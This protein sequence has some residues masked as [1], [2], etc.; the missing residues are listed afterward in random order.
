MPD[1]PKMFILRGLPGSGKSTLASRLVG[2]GAVTCSADYY[3]EVDGEYRFDPSK[4]PEAHKACREAAEAACKAGL[5]VIIDNTNI[6]RAWMLPY[7]NLA[8]QYGYQVFEIT[9]GRPKDRDHAL[10]CARRN[11]HGVPEKTVLRMSR[12]FEP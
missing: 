7:L 9:V 11:T 12:D 10:A 1:R 8:E 3:F 6:K 2:G 4:L 5:D